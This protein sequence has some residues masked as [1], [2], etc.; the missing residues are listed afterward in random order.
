MTQNLAA[1]PTASAV[2]GRENLPYLVAGFFMLLKAG[3]NLLYL[4][5]LTTFL[6]NIG[7]SSLPWVYLL[8]NIVFIL[9][10]F[11][12][13]SRIAGY[14]GHWLLSLANWPAAMLSFVAAFVFPANTFPVLLSFLVMAMLNDLVTTQAFTA[15]LNHFFSVSESRRFTPII[16]ASGSF[17]FILSGLLLKFVLDFVGIRGLLVGNGMIILLSSLILRL[18]KPVEAA[19]MA[20]ADEVDKLPD[21]TVNTDLAGE[22]SMQ[23]PLA[24]L[25]NIS[26]FL[27]LF[28]KYLVDFLFAA[29]LT[30]YFSS[31]NDL[32]AFM[33][34]FGASA[35]FAVIG[36]QTFV[37][38]R[39]FAAFSI[40]KILAVMP[41]A[42]TILCISASFSLKFAVIAMV[43]FLVLLNSKNFTVPAT[44]ILMGV[45][46]QKQ[47]IFYRRDMSIV[48]SISST[49]VGIFLLLVRNSIGTE[50]LFLIAAS[51]YLMISVV[52]YQIDKAYLA[53]LRRA[54]DNR[55]LDF[56]EDQ[57]TSLRFLQYGERLQQLQQLL[58][59][60]NS[61]IR[62]R[63]IEEVS[64]LP[65]NTAAK[66]LQPLLETETD[67]R[68][69]TSI[70]RNLLQLAPQSSAQH[71]QRVLAETN[72]QRLRADIIETIGKVR[73]PAISQD[74]VLSFLDSPHH[75]VRASAIIST[76]R[77][78]RQPATL[79]RAMHK[80]AQMAHDVEELMRASAAAV[81]GELGLPLFV[82]ALSQLACSSETVV[83][84]NAAS[85]LARMQTPAAVVALENML[86]HD[87][88]EVASRVESLL[89]DSTRDSISRISR[90]LPGITAEER[91]K[92]TA[93]LRS[94]HH[95][96]SQELLANIL[97]IDN[98]DQRR[99][100]IALLEKSDRELVKIMQACISMNEAD[101]V[102]LSI[103]PLIDLSQEYAGPGLPDWASLL[104]IIA[105]GTLEN[106]AKHEDYLPAVERLLAMIWY[107]RIV[108]AQ[109]QISG[110]ALEKWQTRAMTLTRLLICFS[111]DPAPMGRSINELK[112]GKAYSRGMAA[113]Y[114]EARAGRRF[115]Q[116]LLP[117][118]DSSFVMPQEG[119]LLIKLA[120]SRGLII[121]EAN[122]AAARN[123]LIRFAIVEENES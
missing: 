21:T 84:S 102:E 106:P 25:L 123:R 118:V 64:L 55:Q 108:I 72:D 61:G 83:A 34:V 48:C 28:N 96:D 58:T 76:I 110:S 19:R 17:G 115:A 97:C 105:G 6:D 12:F 59:D 119:E 89:A 30:T 63:A 53:T 87:N 101:R 3:N 60:E 46:P 1:V 112:N 5:V 45:I 99:N 9:F 38:H 39:V 67:S 7:A 36:L 98:L 71:I 85:A 44:T 29:A 116:L 90:L 51:I 41:L 75:R 92:L 32:A 8:V 31:G 18:L 35:D 47:R 77:L 16:Y 69:L 73:S 62:N 26:S 22:T 23:H 81:M 95:H 57:V 78:T 10:Q 40:G 68:C 111:S 43:Q 86:S 104:G 91:Q 27:I 4:S 70:A 54:I 65:V 121:E 11:Q 107:E 2:G 20:E 100:L 114:I 52:H 93:R 24:R 37:M 15:M 94:G 13:M 103:A 113:E 74:F 42:L 117:L 50:F 82:P 109:C 33:G 14:E 88:S 79:S 56:G 122:L 80:L 66:L 49:L 120:G